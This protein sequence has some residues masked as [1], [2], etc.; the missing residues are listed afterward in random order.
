MH[1]VVRI[2]V[3]VAPA[4]S[5][6][7]ERRSAWRKPNDGHQVAERHPAQPAGQRRIGGGHRRPGVAVGRRG[8]GKTPDSRAR[9]CRW[10][11]RDPRLSALLLGLSFGMEEA[12]VSRCP[13]VSHGMPNP[14]AF[15][16]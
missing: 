11:E 5:V 4:L 2:P 12:L 6:T 10:T 16:A 1:S 13:R 7:T 14:A 8:A 3:S 9:V 15:A